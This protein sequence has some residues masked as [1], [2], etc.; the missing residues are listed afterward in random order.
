MFENNGSG[1]IEKLFS[2]SMTLF[3]FTKDDMH[4]YHLPIKE[5]STTLEEN[6]NPI[7]IDSPEHSPEVIVI[8]DSPP[9]K[10]VQPKKLITTVKFTKDGK[11]T[12]SSENRKRKSPAKDKKNKKA[13]KSPVL[14][15][16][17]DNRKEA[18][19]ESISDKIKKQ[20]DKV[21]F[22]KIPEI[23]DEMTKFEAFMWTSASKPTFEGFMD[24][25]FT[26]IKNSYKHTYS[27]IGQ[28]DNKTKFVINFAG[29][30]D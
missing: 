27:K 12:K 5:N 15:E 29:V 22:D 25:L 13:E 8:P 24:K 16:F 9:K 21:F 10:E 23:T 11:V 18:Q 2:N 30:Y 28:N 17:E 20:S 26:K 19:D 6:S 1:K 3:C 14:R 4:F 7:V